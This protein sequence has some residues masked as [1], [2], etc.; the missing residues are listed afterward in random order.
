MPL[1]KNPTK[2]DFVTPST[3]KNCVL[4][5]LAHAKTFEQKSNERKRIFI[6]KPLILHRNQ[7]KTGKQDTSIRGLTV[8]SVSP[9]L[10][11]NSY[12][13]APNA[14]SN[15]SIRFCTTRSFAFQKEVKLL[16]REL[17][18]ERMVCPTLPRLLLKT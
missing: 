2:R 15:A 10:G 3:R 6:D 12:S 7:A 17:I 9:L 16:V 14:F 4:F 5:L 1:P 18:R 13:I 11:E 8:A